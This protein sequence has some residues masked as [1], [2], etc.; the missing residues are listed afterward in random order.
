MQETIQLLIAVLA[1]LSAAMGGSPNANPAPDRP[2]IVQPV[3]PVSA[4]VVSNNIA[5]TTPAASVSAPVAS[6]NV[7]SISTPTLRVVTLPAAAPTLRA[8]TLPAATPEARK[9]IEVKGTVQSLQGNTIVVNGQRIVLDPGAQIR[10]TLDVGAAVQIEGTQVGNVMIARQIE[11]KGS[12]DLQ[13][14]S[15]DSKSRQPSPEIKSDNSSKGHDNS[16]SEPKKEEKNEDKKDD[17]KEDKH[18]GKKDD[19]KDDE[20]DD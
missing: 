11:V 18:D 10:G 5:T 7:A 12:D 2:A 15:D 19:H 13:V 6:S 14:K 17:R 3:V 1:G 20:H 4:P 9:E 16:K 8:V